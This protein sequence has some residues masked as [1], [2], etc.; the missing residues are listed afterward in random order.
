MPTILKQGITLNSQEYKLLRKQTQVLLPGF[1]AR[2]WQKDL[3]AVSTTAVRKPHI[4]PGKVPGE[5]IIVYDDFS[6][7]VWGDRDG[8]PGT[9]QYGTNIECRYPGRAIH[10]GAITQNAVSA[11]TLPMEADP[12]AVLDHNG[13][14]LVVAGRFVLKYTAGAWGSDKDFAT[15]KAATHACIYQN[16]LY[17]PMGMSEYIQKRSAAGSWSQSA[18]T[19][20]TH[21]ATAEDRFWRGYSSSSIFYVSNVGPEDDPTVLANYSAGI[22]IGDDPYT[23]IT[24]MSSVGVKVAVAK[25]DGLYMGDKYAIF[26]N[27]LPDVR[28]VR[29]GDNGKGLYTRGAEVF[30]PF[31]NGLKFYRQGIADEVG[32]NTYVLNAPTSADTGQTDIPGLL[33]TAMASDA[34]WFYMATAP[35]FHPAADPTGF[36]KTTD[37]SAYTSYLSEVGDNSPSTVAALSSLDTVANN[38]WVVIGYSAAFYGFLLGVRD[39]NA[40]ASV[41]TVQYWNGSA[42][43]AMNAAA[44]DTSRSNIAVD[45][46][47]AGG[48]SL[49]KNGQVLW[50]K[51][52]TDWASSTPTGLAAGYYVRVSFSAALS[53]T[54]NISECRVLTTAPTCY[55]WAGRYTTGNDIVPNRILWHT[56]GSV[57]A[58]RITALGV[59]SLVDGTKALIAAGRQLI[60][61]KY[62]DKFATELSRFPDTTARYLY[63]PKEDCGLPFVEKEIIDI[64]VVGRNQTAN[65]YHNLYYRVNETAGFTAISGNITSSPT[66]KTVSSVSS[67]IKGYYL[68]AAV[69]FTTGTASDTPLEL[70]RL[71]IRV[72]EVPTYKEAYTAYVEIGSNERTRVDV[73]ITNL[74]A[75]QG[76]VRTLVDPMGVSKTVTVNE[77]QQVEVLQVNQANPIAVVKLVMTEA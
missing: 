18:D 10:D 61:H 12:V 50:Y 42:W 59:T 23:A 37:G 22:S 34:E 7:G 28:S 2:S 62:L 27:V 69:L 73:E 8:L 40:N 30:Y 38:D 15:G 56:I 46:T 16:I 53:A 74:E 1:T 41:M 35:A 4:Q 48:K 24:G 33:P 20:A 76:T 65:N 60:Y 39:P 29:D 70:N 5:W 13:T 43:A 71:E 14:P 26:P 49:N 75:S 51:A 9:Y 77:V 25:E 3:V 55:L 45:Y 67:A 72:R 32:P 47:T 68:Q 31:V 64:S 19:Y 11:A 66:T 54:V 57:A 58:P 17:C 52:P 21:A 6:Q 36:A 44:G 63:L